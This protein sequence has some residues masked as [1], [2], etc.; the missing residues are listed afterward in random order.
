MNKKLFL[1]TI[2]L[3]VVFQLLIGGIV[4]G[5]VVTRGYSS[6]ELMPAG[7]VVSLEK[8]GSNTIEK[9]TTDNELLIAGVVTGANDSLL[10]LQPEGSV[11][12][13]ATEGGLDVLAATVNGDINNGD[14]LILSPLA[15]I[16]AKDNPDMKNGKYLGVSTGTLNNQT[17]GAK[18]VEV[19]QNNGGKKTVTIGG[20]PAKLMIS[21][22]KP[23]ISSVS[24][25]GTNPA[26]RLAKQITGK[27]VSMAKIITALVILVTAISITGVLLY[28]SIRG[29]FTSLGRNPLS[30]DSLMTGLIRVIIVSLIVLVGGGV[31]S[32]AIL[33]L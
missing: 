4:Y 20:I 25:D 8:K 32:Y 14:K 23:I 3:S 13:V 24:T 1:K 22:R 11:V 9:A 10:D 33:T 30:R 28:S 16:M 18:Q 31:A 27:S 12:R 17:P 6:K 29:T 2:T 19:E 5:A 21:E 26:T 7:T 15:G